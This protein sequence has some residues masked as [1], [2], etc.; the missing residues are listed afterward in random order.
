MQRSKAGS[1]RVRGLASPRHLSR[2]SCLLLVTLTTP[3]IARFCVQRP[4]RCVDLRFFAGCLGFLDCWIRPRWP[5]TI[6]VILPLSSEYWGKGFVYP[7]SARA[8]PRAA[9]SLTVIPRYYGKYGSLV[10]LGKRCDSILYACT[11]PPVS[12]LVR[13]AK[14]VLCPTYFTTWVVKSSN[15]SGKSNYKTK[16]LTHCIP[17]NSSHTPGSDHALDEM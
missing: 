8:W 3:T 16:P 10:A 15:N 11:G 6:L 9:A 5:N 4:S 1:P 13:K 17:F 14:L 12:P 7:S 2:L